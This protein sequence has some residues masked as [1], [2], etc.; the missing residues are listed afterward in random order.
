MKNPSLRSQNRCQIL[1]FTLHWKESVHHPSFNPFSLAGH[2][3]RAS[4]PPEKQSSLQPRS[5]ERP[6]SLSRRSS[7]RSRRIRLGSIRS[8]L[9]T[10]SYLCSPSP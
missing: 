5:N 7:E 2:G 4:S 1:R 6:S 10:Q 9:P 8:I 3:I